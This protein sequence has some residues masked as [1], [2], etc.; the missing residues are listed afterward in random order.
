MFLFAFAFG[1]STHV[2]SGL[3]YEFL[4]F[5]YSRRVFLYL[6]NLRVR[7]QLVG[8]F[9]DL[10]FLVTPYR[11]VGSVGFSCWLHH[12]PCNPCF[13]KCIFLLLKNLMKIIAS[14]L[15]I[16]CLK[17]LG[18]TTFVAENHWKPLEADVCVPFHQCSFNF[19]H[20]WDVCHLSPWRAL[21]WAVSGPG[22]DGSPRLR[23][24][25][26]GCTVSRRGKRAPM[27]PGYD[28]DQ[29]NLKIFCGKKHR[30]ISNFN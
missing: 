10:L 9:V 23:M 19:H 12:P 20:S 13:F 7:S 11:H 1:H 26:H 25:A 15:H 29:L 27:A 17:M 28:F 22:R 5:F 8:G 18:T 24:A 6:W 14:N 2:P 3:R 21:P 30:I 16:C 4:V